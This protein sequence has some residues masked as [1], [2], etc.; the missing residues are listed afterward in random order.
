M[1][2]TGLVC[3]NSFWRVVSVFDR[4]NFFFFFLSRTDTFFRCHCHGLGVVSRF[5]L[6]KSRV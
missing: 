6:E 3:G 4:V 1:D 5:C 2:Y